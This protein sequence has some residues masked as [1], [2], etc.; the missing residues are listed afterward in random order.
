[1][2]PICWLGLVGI[3]AAGAAIFGLLTKGSSC[4]GPDS[5]CGCG[6]KKEAPVANETP[7]SKESSTTVPGI[8]EKKEKAINDL[9]G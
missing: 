8:D 5:S 3:A 6:S 9:I 4:K 7:V 2:E 1:M